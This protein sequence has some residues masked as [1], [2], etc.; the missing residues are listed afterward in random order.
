LDERS[1]RRVVNT[2]SQ[3]GLDAEQRQSNLVD[4]FKVDEQAFK[5]IKKIALIDDVITTGATVSA[6]AKT[7]HAVYPNIEIEAWAVAK[8]K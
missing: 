2:T 3:T 1:L 5:M 6:I 7:I 4:A 8:T